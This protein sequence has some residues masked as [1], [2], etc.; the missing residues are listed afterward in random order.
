M[1]LQRAL[2]EFYHKYKDTDILIDTFKLISYISDYCCVD[3][4]SNEELEIY[5]KVV[6]QIN[7]VRI[8]KENGEEE[9][10]KIIKGAFP[11]ITNV[12]FSEYKL[13]TFYTVKMFYQTYIESEYKSSKKIVKKEKTVKEIK[14]TVEIA[15]KPVAP[16]PPK[17]KKA[18]SKPRK[19][20]HVPKPCLIYYTPYTS[21]SYYHYDVNCKEMR[22][23]Y[24]LIEYFNEVDYKKIKNKNQLC[25]YCSNKTPHSSQIIES[26]LTLKGILKKISKLPIFEATAL[27]YDIDVIVDKLRMAGELVNIDYNGLKICY[28]NE[29]LSKDIFIEFK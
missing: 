10:L 4:Q 13:C 16:I 20:K 9:G 27:K 15:E 23:T 29:F 26:G 18:P 22:K 3:F 5:I 24:S 11:L 8:L 7:L 25:P 6:R 2:Y 1:R 19:P 14:Q 21:D 17:P 28:M 12:T